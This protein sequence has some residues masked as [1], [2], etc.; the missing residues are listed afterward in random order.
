MLDMFVSILTKDKNVVHIDNHALAKKRGEDFIHDSLE[1]SWGI[2][3]PKRQY[4]KLEKALWRTKCSLRYIFICDPD[5]MVP[6][7]QIK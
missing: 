2:S 3:Q 4:L 6:R 5:L 7:K 1:G